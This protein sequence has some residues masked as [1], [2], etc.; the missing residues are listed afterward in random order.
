MSGDIA[1]LIKNR[2]AGNIDLM[3]M[4]FTAKTEILALSLFGGTIEAEAASFHLRKHGDER[5]SRV[6]L[7][8]RDLF[9]ALERR[10]R[11]AAV[12]IGVE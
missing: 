1:R 5:D 8:R 10:A 6:R 3:R 2:R 11:H 9:R 7:P 12:D 4:E